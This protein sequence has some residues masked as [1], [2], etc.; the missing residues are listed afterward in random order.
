MTADAKK[1]TVWGYCIIG[2]CFVVVAVLSISAFAL[3]GRPYNPETFCPTDG[4]CPHT[5]VLIDLTDTLSNDQQ[6]Y[7]LNYVSRVKD[8]LTDFERLSIFTLTENT[9]IVPE[10]VFSKCNPGDGKEANELYQ[11]PGKMKLRFDRFFSEPFKEALKSMDFEKT[12]D[13]SPIFETI[14]ELAY[15]DDF[16]KDVSER[17]L[18][19]ISDMMHHTSSYSH[20]R[21]SLDYEAFSKMP[22]ADEVR[23][24]LD[25]VTVRIVYLLRPKLKALQ[26]EAHLLF[27][28]KY[29]EANGAAVAEVRHVR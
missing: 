14:R 25:S 4:A 6:K 29:F 9:Y 18:I 5:I 15:R 23:V 27:W 21:N 26:G 19:I 8:R 16:G 24:D 20:Y 2:L 22:Y 10:P 13:R 3:R 17:T 28:E 1:K 11:N 12:D 7:V